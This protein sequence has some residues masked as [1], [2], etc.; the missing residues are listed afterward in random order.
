MVFW[1]SWD[2]VEGLLYLNI[3]PGV[4]FRFFYIPFY[5]KWKPCSTFF[6]KCKSS[7]PKMAIKVGPKSQI[8]QGFHLYHLAF[9]RK[10]Y[11]KLFFTSSFSQTEAIWYRF[12]KVWKLLTKDG[13]KTSFL[14]SLSS[15]TESDMVPFFK[16][17]KNLGYKRELLWPSLVQIFHTFEKRYHIAFILARKGYQKRAF[18]AIFGSDFSYFKK[19]YHMAFSLARRG[20]KKWAS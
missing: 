9:S 8:L 15:Q 2:T 1:A 4:L 3:L 11:C 5:P 12:L 6:W 10:G 16:D 13:H 7:E 17:V 20:Y 19:R 18:M 14:I